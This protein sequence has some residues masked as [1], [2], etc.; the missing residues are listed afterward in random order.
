[1]I[2]VLCLY[3]CVDDNPFDFKLS[4]LMLQLKIN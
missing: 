2:V 1:M 4:Y 3:S